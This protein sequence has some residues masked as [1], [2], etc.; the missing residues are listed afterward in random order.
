MTF[1]ITQQPLS[2]TLQPHHMNKT[3][4]KILI[5]TLLN[6]ILILSIVSIFIFWWPKINNFS[7]FEEFKKTL[8]LNKEPEPNSTPN[9]CLYKI[10]IYLLDNGTKGRL[11]N[12]IKKNSNLIPSIFKDFAFSTD[13]KFAENGVLDLLLAEYPQE[14]SSN[15]EP[16]DS[17]VSNVFNVDPNSAKEFPIALV[18]CLTRKCSY[19]S[20]N[21]AVTL[22][23]SLLRIYGESFHFLF[24]DI[25]YSKLQKC[26]NDAVLEPNTISYHLIE[27]YFDVLLNPL[28]ESYLNCSEIYLYQFEKVYSD[29]GFSGY[30]RIPFA[31]SKVKIRDF[32]LF[33]RLG[34]SFYEAYVFHMGLNSLS[35]KE[36]ADLES[37]LAVT[38]AYRDIFT[39]PIQKE[40]T[41]KSR[42]KWNNSS[43]KHKKAAPLHP[44]L[45]RGSSLDNLFTVQPEPLNESL[46]FDKLQSEGRLDVLLYY[47]ASNKI[48][49]NFF[50]DS[51]DFTLRLEALN[52]KSVSRQPQRLTPTQYISQFLVTMPR[53]LE[54]CIKMTTFCNYCPILLIEN[55]SPEALRIIDSRDLYILPDLKSQEFQQLYLIAKRNNLRNLLFSLLKKAIANNVDMDNF[56]PSF[57][58]GF[59]Q[60]SKLSQK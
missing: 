26:L 56:F 22:F 44:P 53:T 42:K 48:H 2:V 54:Y 51:L 18:Q 39:L 15:L 57:S 25:V 12:A 21:A 23:L 24:C 10:I 29:M 47:I 31:F 19:S 37:F 60:E 59:P 36:I 3:K 50:N 45:Q 17:F 52:M 43:L 35:E 28:P 14:D 58:N 13:P 30:L 7:S 20:G 34:E 16:L 11:R 9:F 38:P 33:L 55:M 1:I 49:P 27:A 41:S 40:D 6:T 5:S 4:K 8:S 46:F 32:P